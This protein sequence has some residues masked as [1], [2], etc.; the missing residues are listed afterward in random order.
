MDVLTAFADGGLAGFGARSLLRTS[1][2]AL[3]S[4]HDAKH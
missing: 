2:L 1:R 4:P 3:R